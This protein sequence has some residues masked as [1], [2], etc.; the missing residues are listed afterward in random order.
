M[1]FIVD[2]IKL[3]KSFKPYKELKII[4]LNKEDIYNRLV[5]NYKRNT[6]I[7]NLSKCVKMLSENGYKYPITSLSKVLYKHLKTKDKAQVNRI[8]LE[9]NIKDNYVDKFD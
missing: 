2:A 8:L 3:Y 5:D 9:Y 6:P 1:S 7:S 4:L